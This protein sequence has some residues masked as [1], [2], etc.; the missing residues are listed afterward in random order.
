MNNNLKLYIISNVIFYICCKIHR[1]KVKIVCNITKNIPQVGAKIMYIY[2][3][4]YHTIVTIY[5]KY[6][7]QLGAKIIKCKYIINNVQMHQISNKFYSARYLVLVY[8]KAKSSTVWYAPTVQYVL[9]EILCVYAPCVA[10]EFH[11]FLHL[12]IP[13]KNSAAEQLKEQCRRFS[14]PIFWLNRL[15]LCPLWTG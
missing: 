5:E 11:T 10:N 1:C 7:S 2:S 4:K 8:L 9:L 12:F 15:Y 3:P 13:N 6:I 14:T